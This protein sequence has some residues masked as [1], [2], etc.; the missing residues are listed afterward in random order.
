MDRVCQNSLLVSSLKKNFAPC[1]SAKIFFFTVG[2]WK[3]SLFLAL[4]RLRGS[5][6]VHRDP[7]GFSTVTS[8]FTHS[9][10]S[11]TPLMIPIFAILISSDLSLSRC[12]KKIFLEELITGGTEGLPVYFEESWVR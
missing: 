11:I 9:D 6:Q 2:I 12:A 5:R 8:E 7:L 3:C 1:M 4:L 10:G